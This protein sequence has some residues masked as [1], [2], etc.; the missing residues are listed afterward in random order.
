MKI[1]AII[2]AAFAAFAFSMAAG[3]S[4]AQTVTKNFE[5]TI[6][7][8]P[9]KS[10]IALEVEYAPGAASPS[11]THAKSAF[12]YAYVISGA[13][14]S[15]VNDGVARI[16]RAGE[17]WSEPPGATHSISRNASKTEPAKLLAVFVLDANDKALTT[18]VK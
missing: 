11:H 12:I 17:S 3:D 4:E 13:I 7:N 18:P 15:K 14:E 1:Q 6:P 5:A 9:G 2:A 10:L 16:Y 8:I